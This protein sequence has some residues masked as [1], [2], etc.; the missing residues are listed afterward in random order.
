VVVGDLL[1]Q[2]VEYES[3]MLID[4][5]IGCMK[6]IQGF[7]SGKYIDRMVKASKF[8]AKGALGKNQSSQID[9]FLTSLKGKSQ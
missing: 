7:D 9:T 3:I 8:V 6:H 1:S 4:R 2:K 5:K